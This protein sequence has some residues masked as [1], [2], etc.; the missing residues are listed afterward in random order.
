MGLPVYSCYKPLCVCLVLNS[1]GTGRERNFRLHNYDGS[2]DDVSNGGGSDEDN[3]GD[4][5]D[6]GG[7][8]VGEGKVMMMMVIW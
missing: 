5:D 1:C 7:G 6:G 8:D 3:G 2:G 4:G